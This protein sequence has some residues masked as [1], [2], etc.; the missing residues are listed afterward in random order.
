MNPLKLTFTANEQAL[1]KTDN[2]TDFA[3][4]TVSYI[5]ATF[6]LGENWT[7]YDSVR[8]VWK[9]DYYTISTVLDANFTCIVPT[10]VLRYKAKV[11]VNLVGSIVENDTLTDR[12]TTFPVLA[13]TVKANAAVNGSETAPVT[14][15]QFEQFVDSVRDAAGSISDYSYDSEA[16]AVGTR[17]GV[18]VPSTDP[19][20][21]N[22]SKYWAEQNAGL[23]DEVAD[24]KEEIDYF[25]DGKDLFQYAIITNS[26]PKE[27]GT[28]AFYNNWNRTDYVAID[29]KH[30]ILFT[31][32]V[33]TDDNAW[34]DENKGIISRFMIPVGSPATV[35]PPSN[36]RYF[37]ASNGK[38]TFFESIYIEQDYY[39][40]K[41]DCSDIY[42]YQ[43]RVFVNDDISGTRFVKKTVSLEA[44][45]Y[46]L[47]VDSITS[48][49]TEYVA[50]R[51]IFADAND[52][53]VLTKDIVRTT[54]VTEKV[55]FSTDIASIY[56]YG[57]HDFT[58]SAGVS[59]S[60]NGFRITDVSNLE[61][62]LE[63]IED[64]VDSLSNT[65]GKM[66]NPYHDVIFSEDDVLMTTTHAH[67]GQ[68]AVLDKLTAKNIDAIAISNYYP[69]KP[70]YTLAETGLTP[71]VPAIV[72]IPN[73][74]QHGFTNT[75]GACHLNSIGSMFE[76]GKPSGQTPVG[77]ND[78]WEH[79]IIKIKR[80]LLYADGGGISINH[81]V[82][83]QLSFKQITDML[84]YDDIVL[85]IEIYNQ[86][87]EDY[88]ETGWALDL[89]D[90][91]LKT[92]RR[93]WGF[94]VPDHYAEYQDG[95]NWNGTI[96][97]IVPTAS[98]EE[99][100]KSIRKGAFYSQINFT[101]LALTD[102]TVQG[103]S[104]SITV[105]QSATIKAIVDGEVFNTVS[106]TS[107]NVSVPSNATYIR[108]EVI[109][110]SDAI[111]TNPIMYKARP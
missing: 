104:V 24:L 19:T 90:E 97:M 100:L 65:S 8:A 102:L 14:P 33:Q 93:C 54:G 66:L 37:V 13:L 60:Y 98:Q 85:G 40:K 51:I 108:F 81:P 74:E 103:Q 46:I 45:E 1:T 64:A 73:A 30:P 47:N 49:D 15:S 18:N 77:V 3:S 59:F 69:S 79:A 72:E 31:N 39:A 106:G 70:K 58:D 96:R 82:W 43:N 26:Y 75:V 6:T 11:F 101:S 9:T 56:F 21:H 29:G 17:G 68:Q 25:E 61:K 62:R 23:A 4:N 86:D 83:S 32:T 12:L 76:S 94:A 38:N 50:S 28:F 92:G 78:T 84:D 35:I 71:P 44:G 109:T 57:A 88:N 20:F 110:G 41:E 10:E 34:Y 5:E 80:E 99:C 48:S 91:I 63:Q 52:T 89:W 111:Y 67:C 22:N 2:F 107:M 87:C 95:A 16:W 36:A 42:D 7:G 55:T 27:D 105:N 53:T